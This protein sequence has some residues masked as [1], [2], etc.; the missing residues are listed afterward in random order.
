MASIQIKVPDWLDRI[1]A[2]PVMRYRQYR[3]GYPFRKIPLGE[4]RITIVD[5]RDFYW[6]N[7]FNWCVKGNGERSYAVRLISDSDNKTKFLSL[8]RAIMGSPAGLQ[9]DHRNRNRLDNR[10]DNLRLA[11]CSQ[12]QFNKGKTIRKTTSQFVGVSFV[13][14]AGRWKAQI[15]LDRKTIFLGYFDSEIE[16]ARV[17]DA[18]AKKYHGEFARLNFSDLPQSAP[19]PLS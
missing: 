16:A 1:C 19:R 10:R 6:F 12:N 3:Y 11:T 2:W 13:K 7:N 5:P 18:A 4:G 15:M 14:S 9:V 8:H 17:Y